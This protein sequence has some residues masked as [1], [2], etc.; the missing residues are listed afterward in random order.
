VLLQREPSEICVSSW[1][2]RR[3]ASQLMQQINDF[4]ASILNHSRANL[5]CIDYAR[6]RAK[7]ISFLETELFRSLDLPFRSEDVMTC[8]GEELNHCK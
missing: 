6:I 1:W 2:K 4:Y 5:L 3:D 7:D 8:L